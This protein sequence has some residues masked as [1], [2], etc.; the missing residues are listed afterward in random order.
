MSASTTA[1]ELSPFSALDRTLGRSLLRISEVES[2]TLETLIS[3]LSHQVQLG[4]SYISLSRLKDGKALLDEIDK[5]G[6]SDDKPN[7]PLV[8]DDNDRLYF[9]KHWRYE[10]EIA[11]KVVQRILSSKPEI[12]DTNTISQAI[13]RL[14]PFANSAEQKDAA[15][16][17]LNN[18]M[19]I[20]TGGQVR[21][22]LRL[23]FQLSH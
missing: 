22:K 6:L 5:S 13:E 1:E 3:L 19:S 4:H 18:T 9:S 8:V 7:A 2:P 14:L 20:I 12:A 21:G 15:L 17:V 10:Q 23:C 16:G 11:A